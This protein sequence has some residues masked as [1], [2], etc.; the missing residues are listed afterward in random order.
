MKRA[1]LFIPAAGKGTRLKELTADKPKALVK[2]NG[3]PMI[4]TL[5]QRLDIPEIDRIIVNVHHFASMLSCHL[6][7]FSSNE[8]HQIIISD[9][10]QQLLDTGGGLKKVLHILYDCESGRQSSITSAD[11]RLDGDSTSFNDE[12]DN[13]SK[14]LL[15]YNVDILSDFDVR[16]FISDVYDGEKYR[17]NALAVM[18][19]SNRTS[20]RYLLF[21][22]D[23][24]LCGWMNEKTG[25]RINVYNSNAICH[26]LAYSGI[27]L[28][29][30][31]MKT[32]M[33]EDEIFPL[34]PEYLRLAERYPI[35]GYDVGDENFLDL[36][37][38]ENIKRYD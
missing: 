8:R 14:W 13:S 21:D 24:R 5:L 35:Y 19:V 22:R 20:S 36:G 6:T 32:V 17:S 18:V 38:V 34:I 15:V 23:M 2:V 10:S 30:P 12:T 25:E 11:G 33:R 1:D 31:S 27:Q 37:K 7:E 26:K 9:E 4:D 16:R 29:N 28:V 3:I